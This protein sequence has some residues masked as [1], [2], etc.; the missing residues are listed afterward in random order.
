MGSQIM[1]ELPVER[2]RRVREVID[3]FKP[4]SSASAQQ[5]GRAGATAMGPVSKTS[6]F[7][8]SLSSSSVQKGLSS[9]IEFATNLNVAKANPDDVLSNL[10]VKPGNDRPF[11]E[12]TANMV[13][14]LREDLTALQRSTETALAVEDA[15]SRSMMDVIRESNPSAT[16]ENVTRKQLTE[17]FRLPTRQIAN[18]MMRHV[19][20]SL[21]AR[22]L[23][24]ARGDASQAKVTE[25]TKR[26]DQ[27]FA[28]TLAKRIDRLA[29][30]KGVKPS[31]IPAEIPKWAAELEAIVGKYRTQ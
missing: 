17:A 31:D 23:D 4:R 1:P 30:E 19:I 3:D 22:V 15:L 14:R 16:A 11:G 9:L 20:T 8:Q 10:G 6:S 12:L 5:A 29:R 2:R 13:K 28:A 18:V 26:V 27:E 24:A 21:V 7:V 25:L